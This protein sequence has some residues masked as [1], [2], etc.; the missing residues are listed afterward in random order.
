M[1]LQT[2]ALIIS[3]G[4]F[5]LFILL[6]RIL[7]TTSK[8]LLKQN[9]ELSKQKIEIEAAYKKLN[10]SYKNTVFALSNAVDAR[11]SYT[12]GHSS[13]VTRISCL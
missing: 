2:I 8:T 4:L 6:I 9:S 7:Y 10:D 13:R 12:A 5:I 1:L 3:G 11:D